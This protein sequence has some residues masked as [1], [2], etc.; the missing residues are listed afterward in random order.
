MPTFAYTVKDNKGDTLKGTQEAMNKEELVRLLHT[1]G[2]VVLS[3]SEAKA[4]AA[5]AGGGSRKK[6]KFH[7]KAKLDDLTLF[8][9]QL[10]VLL[11]SGV[12]I[13]KAIQILQGQ[14]ESSLLFDSLKAVEAD[15]KGGSSLRDA[16]AKHP[17]VF[18]SMWVDLVET[19]E[20]TGQLAPVLR[21]LTDYL[22]M[23]REIQ[24]K[25]IS[26]L[27]YP[28]ILVCVS[29]AAIFVFMFKVIPIFAKVYEGFG[30]ASL[31]PLTLGVIAVS[32]FLREKFLLIVGAVTGL[33]F[34][35]K[36]YGRTQGGK[37]N[38]DILK[39]KLP[40]I[41]DFFLGI[42]IERFTSC[43][44]M[45]LKGGV[46]IVK[47]LEVCMRAVGNSV[48]EEELSKVKLS[49]LQGRSISGPL[50]QGVIFPPIVSQMI[51]VG[52]ETGKLAQVLE[53]LAR[54][55]NEIINTQVS[56]LVS[57]F[58]PAILVIMG[59][60]IGVLVTAMY[61]PIFGMASAMSG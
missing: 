22:E 53:D 46:S 41:G 44:S 43:L 60:A 19:G 1:K 35:I 33:V 29:V 26:A 49:V 5:P 38:L 16:I 14:V 13:L 47:A 11:E 28:A 15:I 7:K 37:R 52:E 51:S 40:I 17:N 55:Y 57:F 24:K 27:V 20:A 8:A 48:V 59:G 2:F 54:F 39:L 12:S 31:P 4:A 45:L 9:R 34:F 3:A 10:A 21:Q 36:S 23:A 58:E 42:Y 50:T 6:R 61:L 32:D 25:I 56:R 30:G 18:S